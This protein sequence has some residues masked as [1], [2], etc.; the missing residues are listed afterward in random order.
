MQR[1][2]YGAKEIF[3][4]D[5]KNLI[6][7][8]TGEIISKKEF[9]KVFGE[10][11]EGKISD[12]V[13]MCMD[14]ETLPRF[15]IRSIR[16]SNYAV[17]P[18]KEK[19]EFNK[20]FRM[21]MKFIMQRENLSKNELAFIG[22]FTCWLKFPTNDIVVDNKYLTLQEIGD[23]IGMSRNTVSK[24]IK[25]LEQKDIVKMV[26]RHK[27]PPVIY[28]NPFLV[29]TGKVVEYSTYK[30][31]KDSVYRPKGKGEDKPDIRLVE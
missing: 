9:H 23:M 18:I 13:N 22:M 24:T 12:Y 15:E 2:S 3:I 14:L 17:M 21:D 5:N 8:T 27:M 11:I 20:V 26:V 29:S 1:H 31:F 19:Y 7:E 16:Q 4:Y 28:F 10:D 6:N 25:L 30:M